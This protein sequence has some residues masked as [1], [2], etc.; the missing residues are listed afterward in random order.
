[1]K[2]LQIKDPNDTCET[3]LWEGKSAQDVLRDQYHDNCTIG[4][5]IDQ[6][7]TG[8][9]DVSRPTTYI[10]RDRDGTFDREDEGSGVGLLVE[11]P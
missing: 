7:R 9:T 2:T 3:V 8:R 4:K 11:L 1:M 6:P 5:P 10:V